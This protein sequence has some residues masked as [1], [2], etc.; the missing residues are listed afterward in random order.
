MPAGHGTPGVRRPWVISLHRCLLRW[1]NRASMKRSL[2]SVTWT[3]A[4]YLI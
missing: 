4:W 1:R 3:P 2:V